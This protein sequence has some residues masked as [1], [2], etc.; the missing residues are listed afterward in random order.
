MFVVRVAVGDFHVGGSDTILP[1][2]KAGSKE[3]YHSTVDSLINP[4]IFVAYHDAQAL[5]EYLVTFTSNTSERFRTHEPT[6]C[7]EFFVMQSLNRRAQRL[8]Q[9]RHL[10]H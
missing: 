9:R 5:P 7:P 1:K 6:I 4:S 2:L 3:R 8:L 10:R